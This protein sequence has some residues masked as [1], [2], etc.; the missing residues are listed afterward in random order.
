MLIFST[1]LFLKSFSFILENQN[2]N[3][4]K[5]MNIFNL[6]IVLM[7]KAKFEFGKSSVGVPRAT[8]CLY[9]HS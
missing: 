5:K 7:D 1:K 3:I 6:I 2:H 9:R 4:K 8:Q